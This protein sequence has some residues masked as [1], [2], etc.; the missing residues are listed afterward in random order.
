MTQAEKVQRLLVEKGEQV[1]SATIA[2]RQGR[3]RIYMLAAGAAGAA[4][5]AGQKTPPPGPSLDLPDRVIVALT[6]RRLL[7][8]S[9]GGVLVARPKK[10]LY[11]FDRHDVVGID[12]PVVEGSMAQVLRASVL[13][14]DGAV[15]RIEFPLLSIDQG[16][17]IL[18]ELARGIDQA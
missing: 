10:V 4:M 17:T 1:H 11:E 5:A 2:F 15:L 7:V 6:D 12:Q 3:A 8:Y 16:T 9:L 18:Q 14:K 13:I